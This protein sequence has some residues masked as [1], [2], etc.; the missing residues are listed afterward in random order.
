MSTGIFGAATGGWLADYLTP[1]PTSEDN[2]NRGNTNLA[3]LILFCCITSLPLASLA[4]VSTDR[5]YFFVLMFCGEFLFF[6][7]ASPINGLGLRYVPID[8]S[9]VAAIDGIVS[10]SLA[11]SCQRSIGHSP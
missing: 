1:P 6:A 3:A 7:A 11:A 8:R 10:L 9:M 5:I 2:I 4:F